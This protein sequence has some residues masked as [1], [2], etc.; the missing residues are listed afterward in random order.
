MITFQTQIPP[1]FPDGFDIEIF[2][3]KILREANLKAKAAYDKE[4]VTPY[5]I[6]NARKKFNF[7]YKKDYS[8]F[9]L[10]LDEPNDL[11]V[12]NQVYDKI[13]DKNK[14]VFKDIENLI[15]KNKNIF[16]QNMNVK[17]TL[18]EKFQLDRKCG[19]EQKILSQ[20]EICYSQNVQKCFYQ[21]YGP[22]IFRKQKVVMFGI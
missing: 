13:K 4:H 7:S 6:R 22:L 10:T 18:V 8:K 21:V 2:S 3:H 5:I 1:T 14:F 20:E 9:R 11:R 12:L 19:L 15:K 17:K 16:I